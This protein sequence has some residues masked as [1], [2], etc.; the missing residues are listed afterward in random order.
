MTGASKGSHR[1][2]KVSGDE[3]DA[4]SRRAKNYRR[5]RARERAYINRKYHKRLRKAEEAPL[6]RIKGDEK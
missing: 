2:P 3:Q 4:L 1:I 5:W 6:T